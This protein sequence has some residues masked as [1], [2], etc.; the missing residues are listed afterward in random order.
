MKQEDRARLGLLMQEVTHRESAE[1]SVL[2]N[3]DTL[4][5]G[6]TGHAIQEDCAPFGGT[7]GSG[8]GGGILQPLKEMITYLNFMNS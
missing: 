1:P 5:W 6:F 7:G 8:G 2:F 4:A 3:A